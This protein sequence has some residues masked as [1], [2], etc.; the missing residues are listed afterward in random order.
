MTGSV[1][2]GGGIAHKTTTLSPKEYQA[3]QSALTKLKVSASNISSHL[4]GT[5]Q[6]ATVSSG[7]P[8]TRTPLLHGQGSDTFIGGVRSASAASVSSI[9]NDTVMSGSTVGTSGQTG[10][11]HRSVQQFN[12]SNDTVNVAGT[13]AAGVKADSKETKG[14]HTVTLSDKTTINIAGLSQHDITKLHH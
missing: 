7:S 5:T 4:T 3:A 1:T 10:E 2:M 6:S 9:G 11:P 13:T 8:V 12:L 14:A